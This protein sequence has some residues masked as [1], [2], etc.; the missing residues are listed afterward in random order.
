MSSLLSIGKSGL[1]AAQ[2]GLAT[3]GHNITNASVAGFSRQQVVQSTTKPIGIGVGFVGTG[4]EVAQIK[5]FYDDF[6]N[7]QLMGAQATQSSVDAYYSQ[8][9]QIDNML[10]DSSIGI[11][12]ALQDFFKGV[13][14]ANSTPSLPAA[15]DSML[16][17]AQTL[18]SRFQEVSGRLTEIQAG[19]NSTITASVAQINSYAGEIAKLNNQIAGLSLDKNNPPNDLLDRRDQLIRELNQHIQVNVMP[20]DNNMLSLSF[21]SG[22][23]LVIG[24]TTVELGVST[25]PTDPSRVTVG[26]Q[27]SGGVSALPDSAFT[28][29]ALGGVMKFRSESLDRVQNSLGQMAA[30]LAASF[31]DQHRLGQDLNGDLGG[32]FFAVTKAYV[33]YD[34]RNS[35]S[36]AATIDATITNASQL[37]SMDYDVK[38]E[39]GQYVVRRSDGQTT[40]LPDPMTDPV[41][42]DGVSYMI[43]GAAVEG[44]HFQ[45]RPTY[46]AAAEFKVAI[47]DRSKIALAAP[48]ATS[49]GSA[50][51][52]NGTIT[53]GSVDVDYLTAGNALTAPLPLTFHQADPADPATRTLDGFPGTTDIVVTL[54]DG[55][56]TTYPAGTTTIAY[57]PN[58]TIRF[59]GITVTVAG[60]PKEGDVFTVAPNSSGVGDSRNGVLLAGL[61]TKNILAGNTATFQGSYAQTVNMVA[62][63][64]REM[65]ISSEAS[66]TA[67]SQAKAAVQTVSGVNLDEEAADLLRYQQAYQAA[68][69]VMQVA[70]ELFDTLLSLR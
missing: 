23:P 48:V 64:T 24:A 53:P 52:G 54:Q 38:Y 33:G 44:D 62:N 37:T 66:E 26:Y 39:G 11:S 15:R 34:T 50:N 12:P 36:S 67:V 19:V 69:K 6:L 1:L 31:N 49:V 10:A 2:T 22:Q 5:R 56:S 51:K 21:G 30:G 7:K 46:N 20:S 40:Y 27:T 17:A 63:K 43:T 9:S 35:P 68:G 25:S 8:I 45:V 58:A 70:S 42:I 16:S 13:Q 59:N 41:E 28:G 29:G 61:Q 65:Q 3:A 47:T 60:E 14:N 18:A 4:T 55:S 32:N 57:E